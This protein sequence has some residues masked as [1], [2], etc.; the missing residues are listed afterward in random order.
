MPSKDTQFKKGQSGN[1]RGRPQGKK[2][3]G[4]YAAE[5]LSEASAQI[6][7][8]VDGKR[9]TMSVVRAGMKQLLAKAASG[10]LPA[11]KQ[12]LDRIEALDA[13][14]AKAGP[15]E[16]YTYSERDREIIEHVYGKLA[17]S[18]D[19]AGSQRPQPDGPGNLSV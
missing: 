8:N 19:Q 12:V 16:T 18:A 4:T 1:Y 9:M 13:A 7:V 5:F 17:A 2:N 3:K 11:I 10:D 14:A 15:K 6:A